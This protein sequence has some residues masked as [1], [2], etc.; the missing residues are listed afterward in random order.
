MSSWSE[1]LEHFD[2]RMP[3]GMGPLEKLWQSEGNEAVM[4]QSGELA[5]REREAHIRGVHEAEGRLHREYETALTGAR[6]EFMR[7]LVTLQQERS[8]YFRDMQ[9]EVV[10]LALAV[11]RTVIERELETRPV[12]LET[13]VQEVLNRVD[14]GSKIR[15]R[16]PQGVVPAWVA[17]FT[18]EIGN[19]P[20]LEIAGDEELGIGQ[21][22][23]ETILGVTD[24]NITER[25]DEIERGLIGTAGKSRTET[26]VAVQ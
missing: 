23:V 4:L 12:L 16:V 3:I 26:A 24:F 22:A 9:N 15:L 14:R 6:A 17:A 5:R 8:K 18:K 1:S 19:F 21:C 11:G 2:S 20:G 10:R 25:L 13:A 7:A